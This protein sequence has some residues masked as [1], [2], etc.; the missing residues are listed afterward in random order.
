MSQVPN[1]FLF[2]YNFVNFTVKLHLLWKIKLRILVQQRQNQLKCTEKFQ[3]V[4]LFKTTT[5]Q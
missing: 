1:F 3:E 4:I 5:M 2:I